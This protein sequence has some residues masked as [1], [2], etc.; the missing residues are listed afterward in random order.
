MNTMNRDNRPKPKSF[1]NKKR[2]PTQQ[3]KDDTKQNDDDNTEQKFQE[4]MDHNLKV[5]DGIIG[6]LIGA[7]WKETDH[8]L[9]SKAI[10]LR[11]LLKKVVIA[12]DNPDA[13]ETASD[14]GGAIADTEDALS[15]AWA[16]FMIYLFE[17]KLN[18]C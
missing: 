11:E 10:D 18:L 8:P 1:T 3:P 13:F 12:N 6:D 2:A 9:K 17:F 4:I 15:N 14:Q 7:G 5:F 16:D